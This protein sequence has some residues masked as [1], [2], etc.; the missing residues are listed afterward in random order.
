MTGP[1]PPLGGSI[2]TTNIQTGSK[3]IASLS[4]I[5]NFAVAVVKLLQGVTAQ[6]GNRFTRILTICCIVARFTRKCNTCNLFKFIS[7]RI[8]C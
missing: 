3:I 2:K 6:F 4:I 7:Q 8:N 5:Q 1:S